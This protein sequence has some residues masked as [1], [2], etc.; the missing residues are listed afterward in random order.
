MAISKPRSKS[1]RV[2]SSKSDKGGINFDHLA[3]L[4]AAVQKKQREVD[5]KK[6]HGK[7]RVIVKDGVQVEEKE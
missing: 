6:Q 1:Q 3:H 5:F 2:G 4:E 7:V